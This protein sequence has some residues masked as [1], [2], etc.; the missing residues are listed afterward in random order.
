MSTIY[1]LH[2]THFSLLT[3][4]TK[5]KTESGSEWVKKSSRT[6]T[7]PGPLGRGWDY[8]TKEFIVYPEV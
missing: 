7:G 2:C 4:G 5:F 3:V 1:H 6:A 8:F